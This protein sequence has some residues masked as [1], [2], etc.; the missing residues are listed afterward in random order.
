MQYKAFWNRNVL[1]PHPPQKKMNEK[2][3]CHIAPLP[4]HW[5][6]LNVKFQ[7]IS[8]SPSTEGKGNSEGRGVQKDAISKGREWEVASWGLFLEAPS[9]I[10]ELSKTNSCSVEQAV[11]YFTVNGLLK[12]EIIIVFIDDVFH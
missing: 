10:G 4:L 11:C 9:K 1:P 8:I 6:F 12:Q 7:K 5:L 2:T 3:L